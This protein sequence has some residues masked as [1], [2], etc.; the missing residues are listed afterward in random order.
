[1]KVGE[2][3][4]VEKIRE[5]IL[6]T[7]IGENILL[8][9]QGKIFCCQ[10]QGKIFCCQNR[11]KYFVVKN[12]GK[13]FVV[14]NSGDFLLSKLRNIFVFNSSNIESKIFY[15]FI[16]LIFET[17]TSPSIVKKYFLYGIPLIL[18]AKIFSYFES[19]NFE[20]INL[21]Y[22]IPIEHEME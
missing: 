11:G 21:P 5:N 12:S 16:L 18:R 8:S 7:K 20:I 15:Y 22:F 4:L 14:K 2:N 17:K 19:T 1:M 9:K 6:L 3:I 10:K 13:Y